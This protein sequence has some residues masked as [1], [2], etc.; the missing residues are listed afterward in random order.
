MAGSRQLAERFSCKAAVRTTTTNPRL[1]MQGSPSQPSNHDITEGC[2]LPTLNHD[3]ET[4]AV[5][6]NAN[7]DRQLQNA[8]AARQQRIHPPHRLVPTHVILM[9][10]SPSQPPTHIP[11]ECCTLPTLRDD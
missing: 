9:Q 2:T 5:P 11:T 4:P 8:S 3:Y 7:F 1:P 10:G 6:H